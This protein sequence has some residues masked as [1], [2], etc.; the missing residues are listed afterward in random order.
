MTEY[1]EVRTLAVRCLIALT[2][3][4]TLIAVVKAAFNRRE[5]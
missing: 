1:E 3:V 4:W 5:E 2:L